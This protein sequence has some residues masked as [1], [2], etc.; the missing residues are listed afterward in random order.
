MYDAPGTGGPAEDEMADFII[1]RKR[2]LMSTFPFYGSERA[3]QK[4]L[5]E[6]YK[7]RGW[8]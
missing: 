4:A 6:Y 7:A 1:T 8:A 3:E 2:E 5:D